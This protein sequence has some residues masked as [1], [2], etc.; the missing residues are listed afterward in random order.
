M[1]AITAATRSRPTRWPPL[2]W[3]RTP[4]GT[5]S[6]APPASACPMSPLATGPAARRWRAGSRRP[7]PPWASPRPR[8]GCASIATRLRSRT[9][10]WRAMWRCARARTTSRAPPMINGRPRTCTG[11]RL[12][13]VATLRTAAP[14]SRCRPHR[15]RLSPRPRRRRPQQLRS[16]CRCHRLPHRALRPL[17]SL[18]FPQRH[19][20]AIRRRR[21][22]RRR[23]RPSRCRRRL[24]HLRGRATRP[25]W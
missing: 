9:A 22:G 3:S 1:R 15:R 8:A 23:R 19:L 17:H 25:S 14:P 13:R 6:R 16:P 21:L 7:T 18:R 5:A 24:C 2:P 12:R 11:Y 10:T 20:V 4:H